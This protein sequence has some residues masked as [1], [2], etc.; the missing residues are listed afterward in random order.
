MRK[1]PEPREDLKVRAV[2]VAKTSETILGQP[3]RRT[4][5]PFG[6]GP[7]QVAPERGSQRVELPGILGF[8]AAGLAVFALDGFVD[9]LAMH[10]NLDRGGDPD[11][12]AKWHGEDF[13]TIYLITLKSD[14]GVHLRV[15]K[16][17]LNG[18]A[19]TCR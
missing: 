12:V 13:D 19:S 16:E 3:G 6:T 18:Q 11:Q 14:G 7:T 17:G 10:G 1:S 2:I 8:Q 15:D 9:L 4:S 5:D